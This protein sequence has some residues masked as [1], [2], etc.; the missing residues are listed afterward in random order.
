MVR[1]QELTV[2]AD[3]CIGADGDHASV[4]HGTI[5]VD[6]HILAQSDAMPV[7]AMEWW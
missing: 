7:V 6:E 4:E 3:L 2:R 5:V 1:S